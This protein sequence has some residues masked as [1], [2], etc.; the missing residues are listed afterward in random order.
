MSTV[1]SLSILILGFAL[2]HEV[3]WAQADGQSA[4]TKVEA[5]KLYNE[6]N[7]LYK[8]G[9]YMAAIEKYNAAL[10]IH[11]DYKYYYQ[12]GLSYKNTR[13]L[14]K[15][16][17]AFQEALKLKQDFAIGHNAMAGTELALRNFDKAIEG[18]KQALRYDPQMDRARKG[19]SEAYAGKIQQL[20]DDGK[21]SDA[22][23]LVDE[24]LQQHS[25]DPKLYLLAAIV[26]N[27]M[28]KPEQ[29]LNAGQEAIKL[30]KR[31]A[32][33]AE[34][35]EIGIAYKK[36]KDFEKARTAFLEAKKDPTYSRNAQYELDGLKGK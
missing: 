8:T 33:G 11:K 31:G 20:V 9:N 15:A 26:Y 32:K 18:F 5:D 29:A 23:T 1:R 16:I 27:K 13:Q 25:D 7:A 19:L 34:Y 36:L 35:F 4:S 17:E 2:L 28:E 10:N 14:D 30:K 6:G 12:L 3:G 24:A 22:N 21:I